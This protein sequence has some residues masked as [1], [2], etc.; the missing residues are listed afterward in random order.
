MMVSM[1]TKLWI[2]LCWIF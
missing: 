1:E 2:G